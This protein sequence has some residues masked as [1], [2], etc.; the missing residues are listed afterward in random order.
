M[1]VAPLVNGSGNS[2][3]VMLLKFEV[4]Y[5]GVDFDVLSSAISHGIENC[6]RLEAREYPFMM[7]ENSI[8]TAEQR[9]KVVISKSQYQCYAHLLL[10]VHSF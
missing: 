3:S 6:M 1:T 8:T 5:K 4:S 2:F 9:Y 10:A 7:V